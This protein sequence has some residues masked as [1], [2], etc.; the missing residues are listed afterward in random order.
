[1]TPT[2]HCDGGG[3]GGDGGRGGAG[4]RG[5]MRSGQVSGLRTRT[6]SILAP[7]FSSSGSVST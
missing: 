5:W 7:K 4:G 3:G 2:W 1:M 6:A